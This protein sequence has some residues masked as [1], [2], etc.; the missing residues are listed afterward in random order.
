M[1]RLLLLISI[2][3][4]L[5]AC[6][7]DPRNKLPKT[8]NFGNQVSET[9]VMTTEQLLDMMTMS[10]EMK[11][12]V[13]GTIDEYCKSEGC[14]LTLKNDKG[15]PLFVEVENKAFILPHDISGKQAVISGTA[16]VDTTEEGKI[17]VMMLA[18][19]ILIK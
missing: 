10:A 4:L 1:N 2:A 19:G 17:E 6:D 5:V 13:G 18:D 9:N 12:T 16:I 3:I 14:W 15:E 7:N 11:A 8:G